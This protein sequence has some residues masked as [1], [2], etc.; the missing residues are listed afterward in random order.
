MKLFSITL[1]LFA[2][3]TLLSACSNKTEITTKSDITESKADTFSPTSTPFTG[4][5]A[6]I[7]GEMPQM[8]IAD[9]LKDSVEQ[10]DLPHIWL[11]FEQENGNPL[12]V[13]LND[14]TKSNLA[15]VGKALYKYQYVKNNSENPDEKANTAYNHSLS[16][17][18]SLNGIRNLEMD[19]PDGKRKLTDEEIYNLLSKQAGLINDRYYELD[20][21]FKPKSSF[22][23]FKQ[24][25]NKKLGY[26]LF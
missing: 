21:H 13:E 14:Q 23:R 12:K 8:K 15:S 2:L 7:R 20:D 4:Q 26:D 5:K 17:A 6:T 16:F 18:D 3:L 11:E 24:S 10:Q 25:V 1:I 9:N 19:L 22:Y